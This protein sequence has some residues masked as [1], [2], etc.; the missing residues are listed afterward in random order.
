MSAI[1]HRH[2][3]VYLF[4]VTDTVSPESA[5]VRLSVVAGMTKL[6]GFHLRWSGRR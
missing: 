5:H 6:Y 4:D 2:G 1:C 3:F